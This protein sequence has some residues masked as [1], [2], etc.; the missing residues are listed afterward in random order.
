MT[1]RNTDKKSWS[2]KRAEYRKYLAS[3]RWAEKKRQL[4][5]ATDFPVCFK[6]GCWDIP[7]QVHHLTYARVGGDELLEDLAIVC[8]PCHDEIHALKNAIKKMYRKRRKK[9]RK[10]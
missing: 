10:S 8:V 4:F 9:V 7:F 6:C 3:P 2:Q 5:A 1:E